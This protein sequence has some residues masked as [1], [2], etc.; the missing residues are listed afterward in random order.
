MTAIQNARHAFA[1]SVL[2]VDPRKQPKSKE[3]ISQSVM[4]NF[5][6]YWHLKQL[7]HQ[8]DDVIIIITDIRDLA[9]VDELLKKHNFFADNHHQFGLYLGL[10]APTLGIIAGNHKGDVTRCLLEVLKAWL[11]QSDEVQEKGGCTITTLV[12]ALR[13]VGDNAAAKGIEDGKI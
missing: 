5:G 2:Y 3:Q 10:S 13:K 11:Q 7:L 1:F 4:E 6:K 9:F 8:R 12:N